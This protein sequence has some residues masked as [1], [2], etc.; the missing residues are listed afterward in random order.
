MRWPM[1][2]FVVLAGTGITIG[3]A[4][5]LRQSRHA[6]RESPPASKAGENASNSAGANTAPANT[7]A[8]KRGV[9]AAGII[10]GNQRE[11]PLRFEIAGRLIGVD[12]KEGQRVKAGDVLAR[13]ESSEAQSMLAEAQANL[14]LA[15]A[16]KERLVNGER[17]E[18]RDAARA[19]VRAAEA[20][21]EQARKEFQRS[22]PLVKS[23]NLSQQEVDDL[24]ANQN[25]RL[26]EL[27]AAKAKLAEIEAAARVDDVR[28][29][30]A[31]IAVAQAKVRQA[32]H[33]LSKTRIAAP[34][35]GLVLRTVGEPGEMIFPDRADPLVIM[36]DIANMHVRAYVEELD[37]FRVAPGIKAKAIADGRPELSFLGVV[38]ECAP[39][40]IPKKLFTNRPG[41][42]VDVKVREVL[43]RLDPQD[44]L[45][46]GLPVDVFFDAVGA[47]PPAPAETERRTE[48][49]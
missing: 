5:A 14:A 47:P 36:V 7:A 4:A 43:I 31:R 42:R 29:A 23:K 8:A 49:R 24:E 39:Y 17:A 38:T 26:A 30:D 25:A 21:A 11:I 15:E 35:D 3:I 13:L 2:L 32:E 10:E 33:A 22:I 16:E 6:E 41:E 1:A 20:R 46:V 37:A 44:V 19:M 18:T 12:A 40:M 27:D 28:A 34:T 45:Y 9:Y 48:N